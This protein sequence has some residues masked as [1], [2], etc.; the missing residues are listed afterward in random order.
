LIGEEDIAR[1]QNE[2][3][4]LALAALRIDLDGFI[5]ASELI[6]SP[7]ALTSGISPKAVASA[8]QWAE[9]ARLLKPFRDHVVERVAAI[10]EELAE[11]SE[12]FVP[13]EAACPG[14]RERRVDDL[15]INDDDS[16]VCA[17]CGRRYELAP[18][19]EEGG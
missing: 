16:V 11:K 12:A 10:R 14:C 4:E 15:A 13:A 5:E 2:L 8:G 1:I 17:T 9:M 18:R 7:Q 6:G 3:G 19:E